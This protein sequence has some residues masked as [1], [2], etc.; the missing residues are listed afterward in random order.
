MSSTKEEIVPRQIKGR[1]D[2]EAP[3]QTTSADCYRRSGSRSRPRLTAKLARELAT[4][5][6]NVRTISRQNATMQELLE[7][8]QGQLANTS[9]NEEVIPLERE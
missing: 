5:T 2:E 6:A 4:V 3:S 7:R 9:Q 8:M 1:F